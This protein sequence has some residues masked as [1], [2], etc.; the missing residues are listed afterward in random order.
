QYGWPVFFCVVCSEGARVKYDL[1]LIWDINYA[2]S[3]ES[4]YELRESSKI[5]IPHLPSTLTVIGDVWYLKGIWH[6]L[7]WRATL[8]YVWLN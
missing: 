3:D 4:A 6:R 5:S 1:S 7:S 8:K 2:D